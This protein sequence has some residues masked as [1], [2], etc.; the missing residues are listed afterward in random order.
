MSS[1]ESEYGR[2]LDQLREQEVS[3]DVRRMANL[4]GANLQHLAEVGA[5]RRARSNRL[6]PLAVQYLEGTSA[7]IAT[8]ET[9]ALAQVDR[10]RLKQLTVGPFRGFMSEEIFDLSHD[11]T[12]VYGPNGT[13]KSSFCE[14]LETVMLGGRLQMAEACPASHRRMPRRPCP[15]ISRYRAARSRPPRRDEESERRCLLPEDHRR[16]SPT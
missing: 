7:E 5:G 16:R 3:D 13:G 2:F 1:A 15:R 8:R 6:A 10:R 4:I 11:I 9:A 12:L 14:A